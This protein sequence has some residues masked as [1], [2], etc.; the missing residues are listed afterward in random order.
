MEKSMKLLLKESETYG[1]TV[2]GDGATVKKTPLINILF[3]GAFVPAL[4]MEIAT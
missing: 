4:V 2:Y 3:A 1:L